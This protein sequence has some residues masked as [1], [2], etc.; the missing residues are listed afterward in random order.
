MFLYTISSLSVQTISKFELTLI[1][2]H[3]FWTS[4]ALQFLHDRAE[5]PDVLLT[6][7]WL[8]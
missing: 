7:G 3:Q 5:Q 6:Y 4:S 2:L 8:S 1:V